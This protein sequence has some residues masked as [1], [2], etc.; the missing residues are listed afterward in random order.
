M[1]EVWKDINGFEGLYQISNHGRVSSVKRQGSQG[2]V[3]K[4]SIGHQ[5]K[6]PYIRLQDVRT[7]KK[8]SWLIHRLVAIHFILNPENKP[9]VNH[10]NSIRDDNRVSNLEW[11]TNMENVIHSQKAGRFN[12]TGEDNNMSK[13]TTKEVVEIK[14]LQRK[15][16]LNNSQIGRAYKV[17]RENIRDIRKGKLWKHTSTP[18]LS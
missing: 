15:T 2:G 8:E 12:H 4:F 3:L 5:H 6:Y 11:V 14:L 16:N 18:V 1:K 17:T 9:Q 13:L 7:N 10:I